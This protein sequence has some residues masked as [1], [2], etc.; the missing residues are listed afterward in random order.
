ML[1]VVVFEVVLRLLLL[2]VVA[3]AA[4]VPFEDVVFETVLLLFV[5]FETLVAGSVV[6][7]LITV[8]GAWK[9]KG[10]TIREVVKV[11]TVELKELNLLQ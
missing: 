5:V 11:C 10:L 7:G 6:R 3:L 2:F 8:P 9:M 1:L 4:S